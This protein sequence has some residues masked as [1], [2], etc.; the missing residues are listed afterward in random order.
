MAKKKSAPESDPPPLRL[1]Y[2]SPAELAENPVNWRRHPAAQLAALTD[3]IAE[4]GWAGACLYNEATSRLIDGHAR[5]SV[6]LT[7]GA[8]KVP[9][10]VGNWTPEQEAK[11][12]ATLDP[13]A[14]MAEADTAA[15]DALLRDVQTGSQA[16]GDMLTELATAAGCDWA[17]PEPE[18]GAGGDEFDPTPDDGPTRTKAGELWVIGGKHRLLV[19]DCT[20][21]ENVAR[22]TGG[23]RV[24]LCF[25]SPPYAQQR[26][27]GEAAKEKVKDWD[28]LMRCAFGCLPMADDGQ[29]LVNLGL[30]HRDGEWVPY[31]D[32]WIAWMREQ[33][34]RRFGW[35]VWD[36]LSGMPGD[37]NGRL[38]PAFEFVWHF[39]RKSVHPTK[40]FEC[41]DAGRVVAGR[42]RGVDGEL[43][44]HTGTMRGDAVQSHKIGD[45]VIRC[46]TTKGQET[47]HP[48]TM[49]VALPDFIIKSWPGDVYDP[50][51]G[52]G[53]TLVAAHRLGRV[54]YGCELE[55][56]YADVVLKRAEAEGLDC[57]REG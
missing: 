54:C 30:I 25:T 50:F 16:V 53:T 51:L 41:K 13:L 15:L 55:P 11:I 32:G 24:G 6:A 34:W 47:E 48:A 5:K 43:R 31:W 2:R 56:R 14:A 39:N 9:V 38:A 23:E 35:Y 45:S 28:G 17:K 52:S 49:P 4:V 40:A 20:V 57:V 33:G 29:V 26:D 10:L 44:T 46:G 37:W 1:E 42:T 19:G 12:L 7:Q 21:P 3:V 36:K 18:P 8:D 22:L 27:Y